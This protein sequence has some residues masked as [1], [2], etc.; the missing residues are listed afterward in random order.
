MS[1]EKDLLKFKKKIIEEFGFSSE[2]FDEIMNSDFEEIDLPIEI[3]KDTLK[4][5]KKDNSKR[6]DIFLNC[7]YCGVLIRP[8]WYSRI[9]QRYCQDCL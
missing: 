6:G 4:R 2:R 9:D 1:N 5:P 8:D 3:K 7:R